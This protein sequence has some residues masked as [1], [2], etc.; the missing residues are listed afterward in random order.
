VFDNFGKAETKKSEEFLRH[1]RD[2]VKEK[3]AELKAYRQKQ[4]Q[5]LLVNRY[6]S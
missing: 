3:E 2:D 1:F 6:E 5:E 4:E